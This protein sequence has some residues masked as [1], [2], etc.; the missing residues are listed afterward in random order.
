M[1]IIIVSQY[2]WPENFRIND[3]TRGLVL[4]GHNVTVLTGLPNYPTGK[5]FDF[6]QKNPRVFDYY[7]G[8]SVFRVP[9]LPRGSGA[10]RLFLNYI[11]FV[12][13]A[14]IWGPWKL[15]DVA[16]DVIF[17]FEP[18]PVTVGL[19]AVFF[20]WIKRTPV[21]FWALDLWPETLAA[22]G[23]VRSP[24]VLGWVGL[25]VR[26]I[27]DRCALVLGQS[28]GFLESIAKYCSDKRK[29]RYFPSWAED[30]YSEAYVMPAPEV[31]LRNDFF[32]VVFAGNIG[33]AQDMPAVLDA[34]ERLK[35]N[36]LIRWI[37]V[38]DGRKLD[39]VRMEVRRRG[40][41]DKF[42]LLGRF[43]VERM[44]SFYAH[45]D[46]LLVSLKKDPVFSMTI[47]GK[48][49]SYLMAGAPIIGMLDG[50][51]AAVIQHANA[52]FTCSAGDGAGLAAKVL[53]MA[54]MSHEERQEFG[55]N[56]KK[57]AQQEFGRELLMD[58]LEILLQEAVT[59][60]VKK[61]NGL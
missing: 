18:S 24:R 6:Y 49:Q 30:V 14:A 33:E 19:P 11:S 31:T 57:F 29:I 12:F 7:E 36:D 8:A 20:G 28:Q 56:G 13:G 15:R 5:I 32:N 50:E 54:A 38:G 53:R 60:D 10:A 61:K 27:Y 22:M 44:P 51:G 43:P 2:F 55:T 39:W 21:V 42:L 46:A 45:A 16:A 58:K 35:N 3:L 34:A 23:Q 59:D 41:T 25:M 37:I 17:V 40:L 1:N 47:P 48:V 9:M 52:G 26:F 4:R